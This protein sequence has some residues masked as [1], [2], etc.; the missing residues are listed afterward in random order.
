MDTLSPAPDGSVELL[1][2]LT[3]SLVVLSEEEKQECGKSLKKSKR[4]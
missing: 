2:K 4:F 1:G 3:K